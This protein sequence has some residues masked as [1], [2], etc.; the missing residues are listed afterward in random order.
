MF[1]ERLTL[2][3]AALLLAAPASAVLLPE[4]YERL[5]AEAPLAFTGVVQEDPGG[6]AVVRIG[7]VERGALTPG[8]V[9]TVVY[10]EMYGQ[11]IPVGGDYWSRRFGPGDVLRVWGHAD[12]NGRVTIV[13]AG[14]VDDRKG[15]PPPPLHGTRR[16]G[17]AVGIGIV[18]AG[19]A[20]AAALAIRRRRAR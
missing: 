2:L 9:V 15:P 20:L 16:Y 6:A 13:P 12:T 19:A 17:M 8:A 3:G 1:P 10:P 7:R 4:A 11:E 14:L 18:L 5:R